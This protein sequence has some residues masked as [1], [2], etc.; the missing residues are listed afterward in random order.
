MINEIC[1]PTA[2]DMLKNFSYR[3]N[4]GIAEYFPDA[5]GRVT[6]F[7]S[8]FAPECETYVTYLSSQSDK[9]NQV[10]FSQA[11][12]IRLRGDLTGSN[13]CFCISET[14]QDVPSHVKLEVTSFNGM[15]V[16]G[17]RRN[18]NTGVTE[19]TTAIEKIDQSAFS[20]KFGAIKMRNGSCS[21]PTSVW[22]DIDV[23]FAD[24]PAIIT[25]V[26]SKLQKYADAGANEMRRAKKEFAIKEI[27][28]DNVESLLQR[29]NGI[30]EEHGVLSGYEIRTSSTSAMEWELR[31]YYKTED[32]YWRVTDISSSFTAAMGLSA[33]AT[34]NNFRVY[35]SGEGRW[36]IQYEGASFLNRVF[37]NIP[38]NDRQIWYDSFDDAADAAIKIFEF[39]LTIVDKIKDLH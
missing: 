29:L 18:K 38:K 30:L 14:V 6:E 25:F 22:M 24:F 23:F 5:I 34:S 21:K 12:G 19:L 35:R 16:T 28:S 33:A 2:D 27:E 3:K 7:C 36:Q 13:I 17:S 9:M 37:K 1:N 11:F 39:D 32:M 15:R 10:M 20:K 4:S 31:Y 26:K 8:K